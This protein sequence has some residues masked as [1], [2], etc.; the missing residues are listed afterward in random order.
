MFRLKCQHLLDSAKPLKVGAGFRPLFPGLTSHRGY[1]STVWNVARK[2]MR[3]TKLIS[4]AVAILIGVAPIGTHAQKSGAKAP[5][6][7]VIARSDVRG[8]PADQQIIQA[9]NRLT[10][11]PRPGDVAKVRAIG[12]DKWIDLQLHPDK[13]NDDA[14]NIFVSSK[15]S[16][17]GQD[18]ND[19]LKQYAVQQRERREVKRDRADS[20]RGISADDSAL[21]MQIRQQQNGRRQVVTQL[22]SSRVARAVASERQLQEVMTDFWENHFNI[23]LGKGAP[24]PY[25]LVDFDQNVI[26]PN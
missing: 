16:V 6:K 5:A 15:Y 19:L 21:M 1:A 22:Q 24:E 17:L 25:Y 26:R 18:Q 10:F 3:V 9:I 12:L 8:L 23:F 7:A 11:G 13:I 20:T 4:T 14:F 2:T